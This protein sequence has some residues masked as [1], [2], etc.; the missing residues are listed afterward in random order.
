M[1]KTSLNFLAVAFIFLGAQSFA[2]DTNSVS[3]TSNA[4]AL[5]AYIQIQAQLHQTQMVVESN[6]EQVIATLEHNASALDARLQTLEQKMAEQRA[7]EAESARHVEQTM[8]LVAGIGML[9][10]AAVVAMVFL[11]LRTATRLIE[12]AMAPA[13]ATNGSR[14]LPVVET[15]AALPA[16][17]RAALEF[18]NARLLGVIERLE[19][20]ILE[21]EETVRIPLNGNGNGHGSHSSEPERDTPSDRRV[22]DLIVEGQLYLDTNKMDKA[23]QCF[24][25]ALDIQPEN[26]DALIKKAA[27]LEKLGQIEKA[28]TCYDRAINLGDSST[29]ALLQKGGMLNRLARYDEALQ[30]YERALQTQEKKAVIS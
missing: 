10:L 30:C 12:L 9:A 23:L 19:R 15:A 6:R 11:Q 4:D 5:N 7:S 20:R 1:S 16:S 27:T 18:S 21:L 3:S 25:T 26:P 17:A 28:I 13:P 24:D 8:L 29:T 14:A 22:E 2:D